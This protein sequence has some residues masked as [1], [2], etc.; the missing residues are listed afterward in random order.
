MKKL[1]SSLVVLMVALVMTL[2]P[3][4]ALAY[5][6]TELDKAIDKIIAYY[7]QTAILESPDEII[8]VES[9]GLEA[10]NGFD[11]PNLKSQDFETVTTGDLAKTIIA[12][13]LLG[14][15]PNNIN[16]INLV[17]QLE[18]LINEDGSIKDNTGSTVEIWVLFALESIS[19]NKCELVAD[20][21]SQDNNTDGGFWYF[22]GSKIS[23]PDTTG[24]GIE[25]LTIA[26]KEKYQTSIDK[27]LGYLDSIKD[28][29]VYP[30]VY[31]GKNADTQACVLEGLL[32]YDKEGV[33]NGNYNG[34]TLNP[35]DILLEF[36]DSKGGF[37]A[38]DYNTSELCLNKYTTMEAAKTLGTYKNGSFVLKAQKAYQRLLEQDNSKSE[39]GTGSQVTQNQDVK[40]HGVKTGDNTNITIYVLFILLP[41]AYLV[42]NRKYEKINK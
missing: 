1:L 9:L 32:S 2:A 40:Q 4:Q 21:L 25:A 18:D 20:H 24:W 6:T 8:A 28:D 16:G 41:M 29:A 27:A 13:I 11:L 34:N 7:Q 30:D 15:N 38:V 35:I 42:L 33:L 19:S 26:G 22:Y 14:E 17:K 10:E 3:V 36:Q 39:N 23:S 31:S 37:V 12:L 5:D